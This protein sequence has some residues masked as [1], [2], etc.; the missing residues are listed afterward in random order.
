MF[1]RMREWQMPDVM[2]KRS[3]PDSVTPIAH[4]VGFQLREQFTDLIGEVIPVRDD[5]EDTTSKFHDS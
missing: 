2:A 5:I 3:H 4:V 1:S